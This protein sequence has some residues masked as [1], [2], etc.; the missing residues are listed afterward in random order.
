MKTN[1]RLELVVLPGLL[2]VCAVALMIGFGA[3]LLTP[4]PVTPTHVVQN[5]LAATAS[6]NATSTACVHAAGAARCP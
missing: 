5:K 2:V 3:M 4:V 1:M 6:V